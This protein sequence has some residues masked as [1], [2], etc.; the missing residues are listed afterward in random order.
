MT[1]DSVQKMIEEGISK[2]FKQRGLATGLD[3]GST[4]NVEKAE[5]QHYLHGIL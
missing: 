2:A 1:A 5:P 3:D 4:S